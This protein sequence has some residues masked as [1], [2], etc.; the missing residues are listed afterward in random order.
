MVRTWAGLHHFIPGL[1]DGEHLVCLSFVFISL[2]PSGHDLRFKGLPVGNATIETLTL[3]NA[4]LDFD[5]VE[6]NGMPTR[7]VVLDAAH[8][9]RCFIG[10]QGS[11]AGGCRLG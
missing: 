3:Q 7:V 2:F 5:P 1:V 10:W 9:S 6:P 4:I 8:N 11:A